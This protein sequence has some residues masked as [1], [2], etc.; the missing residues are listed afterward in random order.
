MP[1]HLRLSRIASLRSSMTSPPVSS[2][3]QRMTPDRNPQFVQVPV[4]GG[5]LGQQGDRLL[6]RQHRAEW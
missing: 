5:G 3:N 2:S 6:Q 1:R 4:L